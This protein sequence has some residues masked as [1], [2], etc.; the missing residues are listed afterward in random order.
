MIRFTQ[1]SGRH[2]QEMN[3]AAADVAGAAST[4]TSGD[5]NS[6]RQLPARVGHGRQRALSAGDGDGDPGTSANGAASGSP[7]KTPC[8]GHT[9]LFQYASSS[10][11]PRR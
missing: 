9:T 5:D 11:S 6:R 4:L 2:A 10:V 7:M 3:G 8:P 1:T